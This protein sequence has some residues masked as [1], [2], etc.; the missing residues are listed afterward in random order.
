MSSTRPYTIE[1]TLNLTVEDV[2]KPGF[3][4][5]R[6]KGW[7][8]LTPGKRDRCILK[9]RELKHQRDELAQS[10]AVDANVLADKLNQVDR[11]PSAT[12]SDSFVTPPPLDLNGPEQIEEDRK[13]EKE[14]H[15]ALVN[16]KGEY[17]RL[18]KKLKE[19]KE[20]LA[21]RRKALAELGFS[22][23]EEIEELGFGKYYGMALEWSSREAEVEEKEKV[24]ERKL[25]LA[26]KRS[27]AAQS[28]ELGE[29]VE[30][31][32][33]IG[34]FRKELESGRTRLDELQRLADNAKREVE[35]YH[36]C[37]DA[38][39]MEWGE[40]EEEDPEGAERARKLETESAEFRNQ[41]DKHGELQKQAADA[42][43]A[44]FRAEKEVEFI[45]E[46]LKTARSEDLANTVERA[47]LIKRTQ[48][49]VQFAE[50]HLEEEKEST[51]TMDLKRRVIDNLHSIPCIKGEMKQLSLLL[52]WIEQ[53]RRELVGDYASAGGEGGP[54]QSTRI[55][56]R[57]LRSP[58]AT[59]ASSVDH[60]AKRRARP[61][62]SSTARSILR[63]VNPA[64]VSKASNKRQSLRR[65]RTVPR[66]VLQA[67]V[68]KT[69]IDSSPAERRSEAALPV[70]DRTRACL[71]PPHSSRVS[72]PAPRRPIGQRKGDT[73]LSPTRDTHRRTGKD[74]PGTPL[75]PSRKVVGRSMDLSLRRSAR[76]SK[77]SDGCRPSSR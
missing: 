34:L 39:R 22:T 72:K 55:S 2:Q 62:K 36:R 69:I 64:R 71:R 35:P 74:H 57:A 70:K 20:R 33:W 8:K 60:P 56:S 49:E 65:R 37:W 44:H 73:K 30:R 53:Q 42:G 76:V 10:S 9:L 7:E 63:P 66:G 46:V 41:F 68:G 26:K 47:A 58:L 21:F 28:G 6:I 15:E 75:T 27:E 48:E 13:R 77:W 25:R 29:T 4:D 1:D 38:K 24:A 51:R 3:M 45:E 19:T 32:T 18:K 50:F 16:K 23:F 5:V 52:G 61:Q 54:S 11:S 31:D 40:M 43:M 59:E 14:S 12:P 67:A 17:E